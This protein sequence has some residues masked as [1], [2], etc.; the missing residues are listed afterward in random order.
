MN[1][2]AKIKLVSISGFLRKIQFTR[3]FGELFTA[4]QYSPANVDSAP[5]ESARALSE[6]ISD[7]P[8]QQVIRS[9]LDTIP[10][11]AAPG[12]FRAYSTTDG[13]AVDA[14]IFITKKGSA[15]AGGG[16]GGLIKII[17]LTTALN[18][19]VSELQLHSHPGTGDAPTQT[20]TTF[21]KEEYENTL[22]IH[23][24]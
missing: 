6:T 22:I 20:F 9:F 5:H 21:D 2:K 7:D 18:K 16:N 11:L 3:L 19:L 15:Y 4:K 13:E 23:G 14:F 8:G 1:Y 24:G 17:D 10:K 12:E